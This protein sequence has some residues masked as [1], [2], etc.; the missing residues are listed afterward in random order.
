MLKLHRIFL[1]GLCLLG[2]AGTAQAFEL[3]VE[4]V[5]DQVYALVGD[6]GAR[7][8]ENS[9]LNNTLGCIVTP[10]GVVLVSSGATDASGPIIEAAIQKITQ[11]PITLIINLGAQDHHWMAN[12]YF[13]THPRPIIALKRTVKSQRDHAAAE[14]ERLQRAGLT[15]P[16]IDTL[17]YANQVIDNNAYRFKYGGVAFELKHF[18]PAHFPDDAV[19]WL[20]QQHILFTGDLV[21]HDRLLGVHPFSNV[22]AWDQ[23]FQKVFATYQPQTVIPGHGRPGPSSQSQA[24]T[25]DYLHWLVTEIS[26]AQADWEELDA[27]TERLKKTQRFSALKNYTDWNGKNISRTYLQLEAE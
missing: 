14:L 23:T 18:G 27:V 5:A 13:A 8:V 22:K 21:F 6:L 3:H 15:P 26:Q 16:N 2:I 24:E 19:L 9:G 4:K 25:G 20:P 1:Y 12:H 11:Q 10:A 7:S 17:V